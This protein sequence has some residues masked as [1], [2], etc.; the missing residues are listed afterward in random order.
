[1]ASD[2]TWNI[3]WDFR[4]EGD[5]IT[6]VVI[7][8]DHPQYRHVDYI[9]CLPIEECEDENGYVDTWVEKWFEPFRQDV[10]SGR[11][12]LHTTMR[13]LGHTKNSA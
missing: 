12:S 4:H 11:V 2:T 13:L 5:H 7:Q 9:H 10:V 1:M 6:H 3:W 8:T